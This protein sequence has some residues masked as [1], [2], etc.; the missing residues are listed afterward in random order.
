MK[1]NLFHLTRSNRNTFTPNLTAA[2]RRRRPSRSGGLSILL[3][4]ALAFSTTPLW[5]DGG[6]KANK[7]RENYERDY[8]VRSSS[9]AERY[10]KRADRDR[11]DRRD[12]HD[13]HRDRDH[14]YHRD[15]HRNDRYHRDHSRYDRRYDDRYYRERYRDRHYRDRHYRDRHRYDHR[16]RHRHDR[17]HYDRHRHRRGFSIPHR[18]LHDLIHFY[19]DYYHARHYYADHGH[20]HTIYRFPVIIDGRTSYRPYAYCEGELY[21]SGYFTDNG[22]EFNFSYHD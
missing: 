16:Y 17:Y 15:R 10:D 2:T 22:F 11:Y 6:D 7:A 14:R 5:A 20:Y 18:I 1:K 4:A 13:R 8:K 21:A 19:S 9:K 3:V 12:R